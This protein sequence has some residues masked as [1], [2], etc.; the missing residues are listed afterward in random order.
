[1]MTF[2][3]HNIPATM[4]LRPAMRGR[5]VAWQIVETAV[6]VMTHD[7]MALSGAQ[8][9]WRDWE[10]GPFL[11]VPLLSANSCLGALTLFN[12]QP[13]K[14]FTARDLAL[15]ESVGRQAATTIENARMFAETQQRA[16][17]LASALAQQEELDKLK[18]HFIHSVS[19]EL[20]APLGIIFG[21][22]ELLES[23]F[24]GDLDK[25]QQ[26]SAEIIAR[27]SRMLVDLVDDL[28]ALLAA[29]TQEFRR[30][31]INPA[32]LVQSITAEYQ[33]KA[34]EQ[35]VGLTAVVP[36]K[37][38]WLYGDQTHLRRVFDNLLSNAFKFTKPGGTI[39]LNLSQ[40]D[41]QIVIAVADSGEGIEAAQLP[42]I[43][44]RFYQVRQKGTPRRYGTGLG[45]ALVKEIVAAHRG[46]VSV[47]SEPGIGTTFTIL[48]P[49]YPTPE[50]G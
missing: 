5:G 8:E 26:E 46:E 6:P 38:G 4:P 15:A 3:P 17:A 20:R 31:L 47:T 49:G 40:Q 21:H 44:E 45:L 9:K 29:E 24:L 48:L 28:T 43:F 37:I 22:A 30:N 11:G 23:G 18:N 33:I 14:L 10:I 35:G 27:R 2:Y 12:R 25:A 41:K 42:H 16:T 34:N 7:Y 39:S 32:Q 50:I 19:H 1:M 13:G 36:P